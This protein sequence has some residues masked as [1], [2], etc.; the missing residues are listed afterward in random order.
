MTVGKVIYSFL[1]VAILIEIVLVLNTQRVEKSADPTMRF[2]DHIG[3]AVPCADDD[4]FAEQQAEVLAYGLED[5]TGL[6]VQDGR[7]YVEEARRPLLVLQPNDK[8]NPQP[9][10]LC[11]E[12]SCD[13]SSS[14]KCPDGVCDVHEP[15]GINVTGDI[16]LSAVN[17]G[18]VEE[19]LDRKSD[20]TTPSGPRNI[21][22]I[23]SIPE[24]IGLWDLG[25]TL[26]VTADSFPF[27][28]PKDH[29]H[30][31]QLI[32]IDIDTSAATARQSQHVSELDHPS[33]IV[34]LSEFGP[35][36]VAEDNGDHVRW[37]VYRRQGSNLL[38]EST[39][40]TVPERH[41]S[42][43]FLGLA[44]WKNSQATSQN[45]PAVL[46]AAGPEGLY[47]FGSDGESLGRMV[48][49][50]PVTG[51]AVSEGAKEGPRKV[52]VYVAV[53]NLLC[54]IQ[55]THAFPKLRSTPP[56]PEIGSSSPGHAVSPGG[57]KKRTPICGYRKRHQPP[58][59]TQP[60]CPCLN[61]RYRTC[62]SN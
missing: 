12:G 62:R 3:R 29:L 8:G 9:W 59:Q 56:S 2:R 33:G 5:V 19:I 7:V 31:G 48:F 43:R 14:R 54:R 45:E 42:L 6:A 58:S 46:F 49:E 53:G 32:S 27:G 57:H 38:R 52:E 11:S 18:I 51:V 22:G 39:L 37:S 17:G 35:V 47:A 44:L 28:R 1:V 24:P 13:Q 61:S 26:F 10:F 20:Q 16:V 15:F 40:A 41:S 34:A 4:L 25:K 30:S 23:A 60:Q 36:Y 50:E 55:V 21:T